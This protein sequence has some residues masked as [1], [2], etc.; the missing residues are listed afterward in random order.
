[1]R[2]KAPEVFEHREAKK[3]G[4]AFF[5]TTLRGWRFISPVMFRENFDPLC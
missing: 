2:S 3:L 5:N 4:I 1:M